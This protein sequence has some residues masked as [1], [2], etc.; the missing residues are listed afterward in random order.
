LHRL[1]R[2]PNALVLL[3]QGMSCSNVAKYCFST[4]TRS[5]L[6]IGCIGKT[7]SMAWRRSATMERVPPERSAA[8]QAESLDHR[9]RRDWRLGREGT[10]HREPLWH[11]G[12]AASVGHGASQAE[13]V[14]GKLDPDKQA[15]FIQQYENLP[16][17]IGDN[18]AVLFGDAVHPTH[19]LR[20]VGCW[21]PKDLPVGASQSSGRQRRDWPDPNDRSS[22]GTRSA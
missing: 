8:G 19:A 4:T 18:E 12:A 11:G 5:V 9:D 17:Q 16:N 3:D 14:S 2:R 13:T 15:A 10:R 6:G 1:A 22:H 21:A 7:V 20:P